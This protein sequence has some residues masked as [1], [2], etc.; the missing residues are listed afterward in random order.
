MTIQFRPVNDD[1]APAAADTPPGGNIEPMADPTRDL[2]LPPTRQ[3]P[4]EESLF[5]FLQGL[6]AQRYQVQQPLLFAPATLQAIYQDPHPSL[7][8]AISHQLDH[9]LIGLHPDVA[10]WGKIT[11]APHLLGAAIVAYNCFLPRLPDDVVAFSQALV[12]TIPPATT[13][14]AAL[15]YHALLN[16]PAAALADWPAESRRVHLLQSLLNRSPLTA[17]YHLQVHTPPPLTRLAADFFPWWGRRVMDPDP[18]RN[19]DH[20]LAHVTPLLKDPCL[21]R[22]LQQRWLALPA[23]ATTGR[24]LGLLLAALQ[25]QGD[26]LDFLLTFYNRYA[27]MASRQRVGRQYP[28]WPEIA[29]IERLLRA[30]SATYGQAVI[31]LNKRG[32]EQFLKFWPLVQQVGKHGLPADPAYRFLSRGLIQAL[33][34]LLNF[35]AITTTTAL[36][37][38][39]GSLEHVSEDAP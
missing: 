25:Q 39:T 29:G 30:D 34:P 16:R 10:R 24:N 31:P 4:G 1:P 11:V 21:A 9:L 22:Y 17:M 36:D 28:Y 3:G 5:H 23:K 18:W 7:V 35:A 13:V 26:H 27:Y 19:L 32:S 8:A 14:A 20:W 12:A 37:L 2:R 33:V 15:A 6:L 38:P